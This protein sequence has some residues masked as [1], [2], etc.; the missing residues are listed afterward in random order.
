[1]YDFTRF[2]GQNGCYSLWRQ[3]SQRTCRA[4]QPHLAG[5]FREPP[6]F[7]N[8]RICSL[9]HRCRYSLA[10]VVRR[11]SRKIPAVAK[12]GDISNIVVSCFQRLFYTCKERHV[13]RLSI[14]HKRATTRQFYPTNAEASLPDQNASSRSP[15]TGPDPA[16]ML[17]IKLPVSGSILA[18]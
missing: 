2:L 9:G 17:D 11:P 16:M 1:M 13:T 10:I 6:H 3:F 18:M 14:F 4:S 5:D 7:D 15:M 8:A 12:F